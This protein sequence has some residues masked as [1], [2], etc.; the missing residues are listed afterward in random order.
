VPLQPDVRVSAHMPTSETAVDR[1]SPG[2][3]TSGV[4]HASLGVF[5]LIWG[6]NF[7]LAEIA[8]KEM[9]AISFS[10]SRFA[11][12]GIALAAVLLTGASRQHG[13]LIPFVRRQDWPRLLLVSVLGAMLAPWLGIEGLGL[14]HGARASL[15]LALGPVLSTF[16][17][18]F[19]QTERVGTWGY[20]GAVLA[21]IGTV[22]LA[23]DGLDPARGYW[24]GDLLLF[25]AL[26]MVVA[27]LHLIK[28]LAVRYGAAISVALR[29][30]I[31]GTLYLLV[32]L[33]SLVSEPWGSLSVWVWVAILFGGAV[34]IGAG[35][36]IKVRALPILGPTRVVLYGNLVPV[37]TIW[38]SWL[39]LGTEPSVLE[40]AA[41]VLIVVGAFCLQVLD[42][43]KTGA[44]RAAPAGA[45]RRASSRRAS[46]EYRVDLS[47][48]VG[49]PGSILSVGEHVD[50]PDDSRE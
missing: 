44:V 25:S 23:A 24:L 39:I 40:Q 47:T 46:R 17:G 35:Q 30:V 1:S 41:A 14:T 20:A 2:R 6:G 28:P 10:V 15:W 31:G 38:L 48:D 11:V 37:A 43:L 32:A 5:T 9:A 13:R 49:S 50:S 22:T 4:F 42:P 34:G 3:G 19:L 29:T 33:P 21:G 36:W 8:L 7:V 16:F 27:E 45:R 12:G 26:C 18:H